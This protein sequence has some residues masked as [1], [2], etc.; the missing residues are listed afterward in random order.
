MSI[1]CRQMLLG[2]TTLVGLG[3][4][5]AG[6]AR[7]QVAPPESPAAE[8]ETEVKVDDDEAKAEATAEIDQ[9]T[10][11]AEEARSEARQTADD[12]REAARETTRD[13]RRTSGRVGEEA[14]E[15][16]RDLRTES[17]D[18]ADDARESGR[19]VRREI[20]DEAEDARDE[21]QDTARDVRR[22]RNDRVDG[23]ID[24]R[25]D[26]QA[27][28]EFRVDSVRSADFGL[29]FDRDSDDG[30]VINDIGTGVISRW[31]FREG[32]RIYSVNGVRVDGE[33]DF[34]NTLFDNR[35]R[36]QRVNVV[37]YR[38]GRPWTVYVHPSQLVTEYNTV[39]YDPLDAYGL[40]L[41]DRYDDYVVV[42]RVIPRSP[43]YYAGLR[44]GDVITTF[45]GRRLTG[46]DD[47]VR[48]IGQDGLDS[49]RLD[50]SRN[51]QARRVD[52]DLSS[53]AGVSGE[54]R[55]SLRPNLDGRVDG[56]FDGTLDGRIDSR[57]DIDAGTRIDLDG[58][59][60]IPNRVEGSAIPGRLRG[61]A[62]A[63]VEAGAR[64]TAPSLNRTG[65][66][67]GLRTDGSL[68]GQGDVRGGFQG[69]TGAY[70]QSDI[71]GGFQGDTRVPTGATGGVRAG[72]QGGVRSG[73]LFRGNRN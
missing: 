67:P 9:T 61:S 12:L 52:L 1:H 24:G 5:V 63:G 46:R 39:A 7:G 30:L 19:D 41:D 66:G 11:P 65:V 34:V 48:F 70:P 17:R 3:L 16:A 54:A 58:R 29:W 68:Q 43:A 53:G 26:S 6:G 57:T 13:A 21:A 42:W 35:W 73:G 47:F 27:S 50:I 10:A 55:T 71:R 14:R 38:H 56:R 18:A 15:T 40:V 37:I 36:N 2:A 64:S 8:A 4:F 20:R 59:S 31:G 69:D 32:D 25:I 49:V 22:D 33:R 23:R 51:R 60:N 44:A 72:V 28:S 62:A 45:D